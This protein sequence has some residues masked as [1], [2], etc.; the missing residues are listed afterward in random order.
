MEKEHTKINAKQSSVL[1]T[2]SYEIDWATERKQPIKLYLELEDQPLTKTENTKEEPK[3]KNKSIEK[4]KEKTVTSIGRNSHTTRAKTNPIWGETLYMSLLER[5]GTMLCLVK[6]L[7]ASRSGCK[8]PAKLTLLGPKRLWN[9]P[10]TLRSKR[11]K[12]ATVKRVRRHCKSQETWSIK[13]YY[14]CNIGSF[15]D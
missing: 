4:L 12:K 11:V 10:I 3:Q 9:K 7:K 8:T 15:E 6:S 5:R 14:K 1:K 13:E 2:A